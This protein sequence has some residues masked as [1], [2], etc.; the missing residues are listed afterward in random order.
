MKARGTL[1]GDSIVV[2]DVDHARQ[3]YAQGF[4][5]KPIGV[6][7]PKGPDFNTPLKL[8]LLEALYLE[9]K[10][11]LEVE[12]LDGRRVER[13]MLE[14]ILNSKRRFPL[15]YTVYKDLR[16]KGLIVRPGMR[17]G[18]D[19]AVY[20]LG[21]GIDHAPFV[22][23]VVE[24]DEEIDPVD[25]VRAGRVSHSVRKTFVIAY[26]AASGRVKYIALRWFKP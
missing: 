20:R 21:P 26:P 14:D 3:L 18:A 6:E 4:Y 11:I 13:Q 2:L 15:L 17:F 7:K 25:L 8:S 5:G 24:P 23:H 22:V 12:T 9:E 10:G 1:V 19:F 16:E